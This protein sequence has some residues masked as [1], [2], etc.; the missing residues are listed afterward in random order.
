MLSLKDVLYFL[1]SGTSIHCTLFKSNFSSFIPIPPHSIKVI[2]GQ[3]I[4]V[5]EIS[6]KLK[7]LN[8]QPF[9]LTQALYVPQATIHLISDK[10]ANAK[11]SCAFNQ[12][13]ISWILK[14]RKYY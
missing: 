12:A 3:S 6:G 14:I 9:M 5:T 13:A 10:L 8:G 2:N 4:M 11:L 1:D 7:S